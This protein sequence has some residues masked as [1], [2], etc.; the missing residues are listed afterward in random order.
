MSFNGITAR[1]KTEVHTYFSYIL[2]F[3]KHLTTWQVA[4][5]KLRPWPLKECVGTIIPSLHVFESYM[6]SSII[7]VEL[8]NRCIQSYREAPSLNDLVKSSMKYPLC[9]FRGFRGVLVEPKKQRHALHR[10]RH[11]FLIYVVCLSYMMNTVDITVISFPQTN[12][13]GS[14]LIMSV[15]NKSITCR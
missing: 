13:F 15:P 3:M 7:H 9:S 11:T 14:I 5:S 10:R 8:H 2:F 12:E 4:N 6:I 1:V